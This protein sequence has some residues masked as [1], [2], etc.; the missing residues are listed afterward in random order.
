M[1]IRCTPYVVVETS[2]YATSSRSAPPAG[3]SFCQVRRTS[4]KGVLVDRVLSTLSPH[5][6][7]VACP[8]P[9]GICHSISP[10]DD[11]TNR[12]QGQ[13]TSARRL[14]GARRKPGAWR[15]SGSSLI[16]AIPRL[17]VRFPLRFTSRT[18]RQGRWAACYVSLPCAAIPVQCA[19]K[20]P[21]VLQHLAH[22][23]A[24]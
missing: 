19:Q 23:Q 22:G 16:Y 18:F 9:S 20:R 11:S 10:S 24:A 8:G 13:A 15:P 7:A 3:L 5:P 1:A 6:L 2:D 4:R 14:R 12:A 17:T 21:T